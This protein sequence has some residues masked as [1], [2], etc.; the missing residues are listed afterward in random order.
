MISRH[1]RRSS[2]HQRTLRLLLGNANLGRDTNP[3]LEPRNDPSPTGLL[4]RK[5]SRVLPT[6]PVLA[7]KIVGGPDKRRVRAA[8]ALVA[9]KCAGKCIAALGFHPVSPK[10]SDA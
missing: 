8:A 4:F 6:I 2:Q 5:Q 1:S 10:P 7:S 9:G 3:P